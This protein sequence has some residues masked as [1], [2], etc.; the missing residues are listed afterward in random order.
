MT[1][2]AHMIAAYDNMS[3]QDLRDRMAHLERNAAELKDKIARGD[4]GDVTSIAV[5]RGR[6]TNSHRNESGLNVLRRAWADCR[7]VLKHRGGIVG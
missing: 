2:S 3:D 1:L 5:V 6:W 7:D 4:L